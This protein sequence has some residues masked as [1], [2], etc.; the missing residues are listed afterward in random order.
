MTGDGIL[1]ID[2][3]EAN[4]HP[5]GVDSICRWLEGQ[6]VTF[7]SVFVATHSLK[8]F[9]VDFPSTSRF[10]LT[11]PAIGNRAITQIDVDSSFLGDW[12][13]EMGFSPGEMFLATKRWLVVEG[14]VDKIVLETFYPDLL[15]RQGVR[16]VPSRG[17]RN[18]DHMM[19]I[20]FLRGIGGR[21]S[22]L[23]DQ[24]APDAL[25]SDLTLLKKKVVKGYLEADIERV[26]NRVDQNL[27]S[28]GVYLG[29]E[30]HGEIDIMFFLDPDAVRTVLESDSAETLAGKK[31]F[32]DWQSAW[33]EFSGRVSDGL[34]NPP[35]GKR[36]R[37]TVRD[38]KEFLGVE[39]GMKITP[40]FTREVTRLQV[41][42]GKIPVQ[43]T[44]VVEKLTS[45]FYGVSISQDSE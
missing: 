14:E 4:L 41:T 27:K 9:D 36:G 39:F 37:L 45:P 2:E 12:A 20:E 31:M 6:A 33:N 18:M 7:G 19:E 17:S 16:I 38:F 11:A 44:R 24:D 42:S 3:P 34:S 1:L 43:L 21:I 8:I 25:K 26:D 28:A 29:F 30:K 10:F 23:L 13:T 22:V 40:D 35:K 5:D 15:R 32:E